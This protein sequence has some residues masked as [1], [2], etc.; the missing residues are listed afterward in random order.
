MGD[1]WAKKP[2]GTASGNPGRRALSKPTQPGPGSAQELTS[3][4]PSA[5]S[6]SPEIKHGIIAWQALISE[7]GLL[8]NAIHW[9][10]H[11]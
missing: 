1:R 7:M 3:R 6:L 5:A 2:P 10:E 8:S 9:R 4:V 11:F